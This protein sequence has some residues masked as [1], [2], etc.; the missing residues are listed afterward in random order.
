MFR[1]WYKPGMKKPRIVPKTFPFTLDDI[2][3]M[4]KAEVFL[5]KWMK[6]IDDELFRQGCQIRDGVLYD[7]KTNQP[8]SLEELQRRRRSRR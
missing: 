5:R 1:F 3:A 2:A 8:V 4:K 6:G 7:I